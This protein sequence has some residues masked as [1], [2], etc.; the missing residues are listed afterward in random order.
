MKHI[1]ILLAFLITLS[2]PVAAQDF[3]KGLAAAQSGD[4]ATALQEWTPLA[5]AGVDIAQFNLAQMYSNGQGVP[6]DYK[7]AVKWYKLSAEQGNATA[8]FG[9][10]LIYEEGGWGVLKDNIM[11]HMWYSIAASNGNKDVGTS[12]DILAKEMTP[13]AIQEAQAMAS[14]C[15]ESNYKEC[16]Y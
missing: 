9:L 4:F 16:G 10:G 1:A 8:P 13:E 11:A 12:R 7:E 15:M 6:Q 5:E 3:Q 2:S 14:K